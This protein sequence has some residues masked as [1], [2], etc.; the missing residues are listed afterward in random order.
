MTVNQFFP[1]SG[2]TLVFRQ[3]LV[4]T[5]FAAHQFS[6]AVGSWPIHFSFPGISSKLLE[7]T[8]G[9]E[10]E[11]AEACHPVLPDTGPDSQVIF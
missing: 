2:L 6:T 8:G 5:A 1:E 7:G 11:E 10:G 4:I 3:Y 9:G